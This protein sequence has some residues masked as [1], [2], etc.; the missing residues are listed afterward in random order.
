MPTATLNQEKILLNNGLDDIV[1]VKALSEIPGGRSLDVS[2]VADGTTVIR[3]GNVLV[4]DKTTKA[5]SPLNITDGAYVAL[6]EGK[7][8]AGVLKNSVL[9]R[10]PRAAIITA[11][12]I[13]A[14]AS[15]A[16]I[17][18]EIKAALPRIEWLYA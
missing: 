9:V 3:S 11:G 16:P 8:Y 5:F 4:Q 12:Q 6:P 14:A 18:D 1:V 15:P 7:T 10:D 2:G 13:N 17:T